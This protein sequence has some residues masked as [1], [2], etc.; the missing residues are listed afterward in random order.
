[1][2]KIKFPK[3]PDKE[4]AM[5]MDRALYMTKLFQAQHFDKIMAIITQ[6]ADGKLG[7]DEAVAVFT[8]VCEE[9]GIIEPEIKWLWNYLENY[10]PELTEWEARA[11]PG[12]GW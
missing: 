11:N 1:M 4:R 6:H 2:K 8:E 5:A 10:K 9:A 3:I 12:I 7:D